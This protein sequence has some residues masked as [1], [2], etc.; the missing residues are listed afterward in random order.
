MTAPDTSWL[1]LDHACQRSN[2]VRLLADG[3]NCLAQ[4]AP[5]LLVSAYASSHQA[6][7]HKSLRQFWRV[8]LQPPGLGLTTHRYCNTLT[9]KSRSSP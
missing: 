3:I 5:R 1:A 7:A 6:A 2:S 4:H 8:S 9:G